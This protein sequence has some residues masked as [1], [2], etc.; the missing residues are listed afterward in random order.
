LFSFKKDECGVLVLAKLGEKTGKKSYSHMQFIVKIL[1]SY[2]QS[3]T[4]FLLPFII[5]I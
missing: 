2:T 5:F 1:Y 4:F 3:I